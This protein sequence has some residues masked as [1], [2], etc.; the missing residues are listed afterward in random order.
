M[1]TLAKL[2]LILLPVVLGAA[3]IEGLWLS[4]T[5]PAGYDWKAWGTSVAD[6]AVRRLLA[7][8]P[9]GLAMPVFAWAYEHRLFT[10]HIDNVGSVLLLFIGLEFFYYWYHRASHTVRWFWNT[11]A[12]HH[13]PNQFNLAA[14]YRLGWFG[15]LTGAT[16]FFTPLALLGFEPQTVLAA[17]FLNLLYQFWIHADWIPKLGWLEY[18]LNTPSAHRVHHARNP[19]YL[20]ANYGG[21]LIVFDRLFGTYVEE[22]EDLPCEYGL[23]TRVTTYNPV[24]INAQPW[25]GLAKDLAGARSFRE[26]WGYLFGAPGW[27]PDG[28]G[29]TTTELRARAAAA[30]MQ[31][32]PV[33]VS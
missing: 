3:L 9:Y 12:V 1:G 19:E 17:L 32:A 14:A 2:Y 8:L 21:V 28:Q 7:L 29:L 15:K 6:L 16:V 20:D 22:R 23:V 31:P 24:L 18:V 26:A 10:F 25:I 11:H 33:G 13:S 4:R 5:R 30:R 27:R